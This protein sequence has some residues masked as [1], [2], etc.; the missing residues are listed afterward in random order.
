MES[1]LQTV[2]AHHSAVPS[3]G[4]QR[5]AAATELLSRPPHH[6]RGKL[7][8]SSGSRQGSG[9][10]ADGAGKHRSLWEPGET[11]SCPAAHG[12]KTQKLMAAHE[13]YRG[14][15]EEGKAHS[16]C[17][18]SHPAS[19]QPL[20]AT[21]EAVPKARPPGP[22]TCTCWGTSS[23]SPCTQTPAHRRGPPA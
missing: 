12:I 4:R 7:T 15:Q 11:E 3:E 20:A 8:G 2:A 23:R 16:R 6:P 9:T 5:G 1:V 18:L 14:G 13:P 21:P 19:T 17:V 10:A 22:H